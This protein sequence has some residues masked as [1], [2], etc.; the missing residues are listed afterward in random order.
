MEE[1]NQVP[2]A[3][4][5]KQEI[6]AEMQ[7]QG[8]GFNPHAGERYRENYDEDSLRSHPGED[9]RALMEAIKKD[10]FQELEARRP[11]APFG[12]NQ[13]AY[14][15]RRKSLSPAEVERI[16]REVLMDLQG[17]FDDD[18]Y[19]PEVRGYRNAPGMY[20]NPYH[21]AVV[22]SVKNDVI[23]EMEAYNAAQRAA[24]FG[25]G[26]MVSDQNL[27]KLVNQRFQAMENTKRDLRKELEA[28]RNIENKTAN[29]NPY[30]QEMAGSIIK[31][32]REQGMSLD[33]VIKILNGQSGLKSNW[34]NRAADWLGIGQRKGF[35]YGVGATLL[36]A[37]IFPAVN[38]N[39]HSV[40]VRTIEE[41][42]DLADKAR[43]FVVRA[44]EG[45]EDIMAEATFKTLQ[46]D[47]EPEI[48]RP[49]EIH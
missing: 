13:G 11:Y 21:K 20:A 12:Q 41:G 2:M 15:S 3:E 47:E 35:F 39:M 43:S 25:Y 8:Y 31:E 9:R 10:I 46:K 7:K 40:A 5:I 34:R 6:L 19:R 24:A 18:Y 37:M 28:I 4:T 27:H 48:E 17:E 22:E 33:E 44:K 49:E 45:F 32:A 36:A 42:M 14:R 29:S 16:K 38:R 26:N 30:I 23:M 1:N